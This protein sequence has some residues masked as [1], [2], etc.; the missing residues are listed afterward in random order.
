VKYVEG[1][2][3]FGHSCYDDAAQ[4]AA[5]LSKAVGRPVRVQFM[6]WDE[7]GWDN[8]GPAHLGKIRAA[9][10]SDGTLV[11]YEYHAWQHGWMFTETSGHLAMGGSVRELAGFP[12]VQLNKFNAGGMYD[13]A[14]RSLVNHAVGGLDGYPKGSFL[15]SPMD[16]AFSFA[17]EQTIDELAQATGI[18][19]VEFRRRNIKDKR[20]LGVLDAVAVAA[21]WVPGSP[22]PGSNQSDVIKGRGVGM[23]THF[24]SYGAAIADIEVNRKTGKI[25]V[26]QLYGALDCGLAVNPANVEN[27]IIG[28]MTQAVSRIL[29]EEVRLTPTGVTSLDWGSYPVLRFSDHPE[30]TPIVVQRVNEP[31][32]G[33][34]E[35][36]LAATAAAIANAFFNA[37]GKR[38]REYPMTPERVQA[39]LG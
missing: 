33:A 10:N 1:S 30:V 23:G 14:N 28:Q 38:L 4:A 39:A 34:G 26:K 19:P 13:I 20:W 12:A 36:V 8:Y 7:H 22:P 5:L 37:T 9:A 6:R 18:D 3:T 27:Q 21:K 16:V 15:R 35:E 2:G 29:I 32:T 25:V 31:S 17:S 24:A 11:A